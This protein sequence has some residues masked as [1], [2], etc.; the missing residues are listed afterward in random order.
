MNFLIT[1]GT[2][3]IGSYVVRNLLEHG[4]TVLCADLE[5][6]EE[7][8]ANF[9][10]EVTVARCDVCDEEQ[11]ASLFHDHPR[12]D[13]V[14]HLAYVMGAEAEEDPV[15][16]MRVNGLGTA[17]VFSQASACGVERV[18]FQSSE[19]VYGKTQDYYGDRPL[20]EE[21]FCSPRDHVLNYS[22]TKLLNEHLAAK[23]EARHG[24][25]FISHRAPIVYGPG[26]KRGT[27]VWASDFASLPARGQPVTL[28]F[29]A[30][31]FNCYIY[32]EDLAEQ[33]YRL[34][35]KASLSHRIYNAGGHTVQASELAAIVSRIV[36]DARISFS[37]DRP[38]SPFIY[39]M[40]DR[41]IRDELHFDQRSMEEGVRAHIDRVRS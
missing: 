27:T 34:C 20:A 32:V 41:R 16:A 2:G 40:D 31:D 35:T 18:L 25:A 21:D 1:G 23:Y 15:K 5:P 28:P 14:V 10:P 11:V 33:I 4:Q 39:R 26:R 30:E 6:D 29:P 22:L 8:V 37:A 12:I 7:V 24:T 19:S 9:P 3:F 13:R 38:R 36:P 17:H